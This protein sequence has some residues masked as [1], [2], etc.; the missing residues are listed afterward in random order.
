MYLPIQFKNIKILLHYSTDPHRR[1]LFSVFR[2]TRRRPFI[3]GD[4]RSFSHGGGTVVS[5]STEDVAE[6]IL[7]QKS[8]VLALRTF[9]W[10]LRLPSFNP[11]PAVYR[12][13]IRSLLSFR[14]LD[15]A[16]EVL[17]DLPS[18]PDDAILVTLFR[19]L[20]HGRMTRRALQLLDELP[21]RFNL[22]SRPSVKVLNTVLDILVK[23]N[24]D[25]ARDFFRKKM[26]G[27]GD[28]YT[29]GILMKGLCRCN[30]IAE[31]FK[32]LTLMKSS[33][34]K[35]NPVIYNTLIHSLCR[36]G[37]VGRA[38]NLMSEM[39]NPSDVTFN[40]LIAAYCGE[41]DLVQA[42][43]MLEK[44]FD[45]GFVPDTIAVT[46]IVDV[47]C[48][49]GRAMEAVEVLERVERRGGAV[50]S[51]AYNTLIK[52]FCAMGKP[53]IGKK[54]MREMERKG[55]LPNLQTYN[56]LISGLCNSEKIDS[57]MDL[58]RE[59]EMD[60]IAPDFATF[61]TMVLGFCSAGRVGDGLK[62]LDLM[63]ELKEFSDHKKISPYDSILYG[64]YMEGRIE[65]AKEFLHER[66]ASFF[67]RAAER[68]LRILRFCCEAKI[69]EALLVY[70][71]MVV[72]GSSPCAL[73]YVSLIERLSEEGEVR[74]AFDI[75]NVMM[76]RGFIPVASTFN[77][78]INGFCRGGRFRGAL[79]LVEE[80]ER[81]KC[82]PDVGSYRPL[83]CGFCENGEFEK[84]CCLL[85]QM[86]RRGV[87]PDYGIWK[88]L[89]QSDSMWKKSQEVHIHE[90]PSIC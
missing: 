5:P 4:L 47:L 87:I 66:M 38:R 88:C 50:D 53:E 10:A 22:P 21:S 52:G 75:M 2:P 61:D 46:K 55:C 13:I 86:V 24:I 12:A 1:M 62:L 15:A 69:K 14:R 72:E 89:L 32:L 56:V 42:L 8:A 6:L 60:G 40:I 23:E 16:L 80:M 28:E 48:N 70:E 25:V 3:T 17:S 34:L 37:K 82:W 71:E 74:K 76:E 73:V 78:L 30:R 51:V 54:A 26:S 9:R 59:M 43:V 18:P 81:R 65:E 49:H 7:R 31:G 77:A 44:S 45:F 85:A 20:G 39:E 27:Q 90:D 84:A 41:G 36:N 83:V 33:D 57:A 64:Y 11:S 68:S 29:F 79:K 19:S 67:P 35:P 58:F 63:E